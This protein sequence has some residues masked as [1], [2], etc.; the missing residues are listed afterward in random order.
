MEIGLS[1]PGA[2]ATDMR[3]TVTIR[4]PGTP[5]PLQFHFV[6]VV[7]D[8]E[9]LSRRNV[10]FEFGSGR[11]PRDTEGDEAPDL[12]DPLTV[13]RI[14]ERYTAYLRIAEEA[15]VLN[16]GGLD[17]AIRQV[18][19][20]VVKPA[21]LTDD[22]YRLVLA[23]YEQRRASGSSSPLLISHMP[24]TSTSPPPAAGSKRQSA[25]R[26]EERMPKQTP[27]IVERHARSCAARTAAARR[28]GARCSC[29]PTFEAWTWSPRDGRKIR[30]SFPTQ[31][32]AKSWRRDAASDV[33]RGKMRAPTSTTIA[34]EARGWIER[35]D[36]GDV[37][38]RGGRPYK[39]SVARLYTRDLE[40]HVI[41]ALGGIRVSQ[42]RRRDVQELLV[43]ELA[44]GASPGRGSVT[45]STR[46]APCSVAA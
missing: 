33:A 38:T 29:V 26:M 6:S 37:R 43:D 23:D 1:F 32:A 17:A 21:R 39:P 14:A 18:R 36:R 40:R 24:T 11:I 28:E 31:A 9:S 19:P 7:E 41:P 3:T 15:L 35:L 22:F 12:I 8:D 16:E 2:R 10:G 46:S 30:R 20:P 25:A 34:E 42:L 5:W 13:A 27:G 44:A 45:C 4:E